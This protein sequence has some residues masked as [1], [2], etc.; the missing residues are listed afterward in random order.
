MNRNKQKWCNYKH[1]IKYNVHVWLHINGVIN[2]MFGFFKQI[3]H[4]PTLDPV[5][6]KCSNVII[7][8][9]IWQKKNENQ[10]SLS[11]LN[12]KYKPENMCIATF[13]THFLHRV[14][15]TSSRGQFKC[16]SL[17][18]IQSH[19]NERRYWHRVVE[20]HGA[21]FILARAVQHCVEEYSVYFFLL[22][23]TLLFLSGSSPILTDMERCPNQTCVFNLALWAKQSHSPSSTQN[24]ESLPWQDPHYQEEGKREVAMPGEIQ[25][26]RKF[27]LGIWEGSRCKLGFNG[28]CSVRQQWLDLRG[29][30][31]FVYFLNSGG[32][33]KQLGPGWGGPP[34]SFFARRELPHS[35]ATH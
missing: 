10:N 27:G 29:R 4:Y 32:W 35:T 31:S 19:F 18:L 2:W 21:V 14:N 15:T 24:T 30:R 22:S 11:P 6:L 16:I 28:R 7:H 33:W 1:N 9:C 26:W 23:M 13:L 3:N 17:F 25:D 20:V 5:W 34:M 8:T 12:K